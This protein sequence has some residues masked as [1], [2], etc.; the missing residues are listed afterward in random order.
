[1]KKPSKKTWCQSG[2]AFN[3]RQCGNCCAGPDEGYVWISKEEIDKLT[4]F[5]KLSTEQLKK[6]TS[7]ASAYAI[8][9][10]KKKP[11]KTASSSPAIPTKTSTATST[12]SAPFNAAPGPS[13]AKTYARLQ[14]GNTPPKNA[15]ASTTDYGTICPKS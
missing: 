2:L 10:S 13:G 8:V 4:D 6:N 15:P 14:P 1:M 3:C 7:V 11:P 9:S 5:L 12:P